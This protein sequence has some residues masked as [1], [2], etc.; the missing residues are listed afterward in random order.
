M[1]ED[2]TIFPMLYQNGGPVW[3][4]G[5][6]WPLRGAKAT[7]WEGG[8]RATAFVYSKSLLRNPGSVH[9]G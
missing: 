5:N 9:E 2:G 1:T 8:T 7:L 4:A 6:N 3:D